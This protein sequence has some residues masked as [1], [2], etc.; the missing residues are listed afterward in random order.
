[1][2]NNCKLIQSIPDGFTTPNATYIRRM[3]ASCQSL[4]TV[5][6]SF[7]ISDDSYRLDYMFYDCKSLT[8]IP[9]TFWPSNI[10]SD[11]S[12]NVGHMFDGCSKLTI[13]NIPPELFWKYPKYRP[14]SSGNKNLGTGASAAVK[15]T[16]PTEWGGTMTSC[17]YTCYFKPSTS[18][19][20][21]MDNGVTW[22]NDGEW[23][24]GT[25]GETINIKFRDNA[26]IGVTSLPDEVTKTLSSGTYSFDR[27]FVSGCVFYAPFE[28]ASN[29]ITY[30]S[31]KSF[32]AMQKI[33]AATIDGIPCVSFINTGASSTQTSVCTVTN[34][35]TDLLPIGTSGRSA[36]VWYRKNASSYNHSV[37]SYGQSSAN[38]RWTAAVFKENPGKI[39]IFANSN[40]ASTTNTLVP[41][42]EWHHI[43]WTFSGTT[44]K[45]YLDGVLQETLTHNNVN[46]TDVYTITIGKQNGAVSLASV[47]TDACTGYLTHVR[48]YNY[49]LS[50]DEI[51]ALSQELTPTP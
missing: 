17:G 24:D 11:D 45:I 47:R 1:M 27:Y 20:W 2:F 5:P 41:N 33:T 13:A 42:L 16:I 23:Y 40:T 30:P 3:F 14:L 48:L 4:T 44:L 9:A 10:T 49:V 7:T 46:T 22:H 28:N 29:V 25:N 18:L 31:N 21:S 36:S 37:I 39:G 43:V 15:A 51:T 12:L 6:S 8:T 38:K 34:L 50:Q 19:Q 35:A 26:L 32:N